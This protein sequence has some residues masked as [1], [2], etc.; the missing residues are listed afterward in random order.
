LIAQEL[1]FHEDVDTVV[2]TD[3]SDLNL[4]SI[5][6]AYYYKAPVLYT[7]GDEVPRATLDFLSE[8]GVKRVIMMGV[9]PGA[10]S[11]IEPLVP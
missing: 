11:R 7:S 3:G 5:M 6:I 1:S 8:N 2:V 9:T 4:I 10:E